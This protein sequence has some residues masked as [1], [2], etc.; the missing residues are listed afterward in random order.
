MDRTDMMICDVCVGL[1][2]GMRKKRSDVSQE[3]WGICEIC[4]K[5]NFIESMK[6]FSFDHNYKK[7]RIL[8]EILKG[9]NG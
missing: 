5:S 6:N 4:N 3:K 2:G 1:Q 8:S 9:K 7:K